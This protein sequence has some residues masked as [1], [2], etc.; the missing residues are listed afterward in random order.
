MTDIYMF[1]IDDGTGRTFDDVPRHG[2]NP[3]SRDFMGPRSGRLHVGVDIPAAF[4]APVVAVQPGK[5]SRSDGLDSGG[6]GNVVD[7][8]YAD[9]TVHRYAHLD[10]RDV[11]VGDVVAP[12]QILGTVGTTGN[13]DD[14]FTHLHYEVIFA[15]EYNGNP[16]VDALAPGSPGT[17]RLS[18]NQARMDP[19]AYYAGVTP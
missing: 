8:R 17:N 16:Q 5:I 7:V 12:G 9:G 19:R 1:P 3:Y 13:A 6:Y 11:Q 4:G 10:T 14:D 2:G 15:D 18:L